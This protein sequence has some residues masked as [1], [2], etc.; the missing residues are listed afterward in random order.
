MLPCTKIQS[1]QLKGCEHRIGMEETWF[2]LNLEFD[3]QDVMEPYDDMECHFSSVSIEPNLFLYHNLR[4]YH[5][6][7][8]GCFS[9]LVRRDQFKMLRNIELTVKSQFSLAPALVG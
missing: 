2:L 3:K 5:L 9:D 7:G 1:S 4:E 8:F 6:L